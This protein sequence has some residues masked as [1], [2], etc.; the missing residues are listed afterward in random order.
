[1]RL[2]CS[3]A[4]VSERVLT[5]IITVCDEAIDVRGTI[6]AV[7]YLLLQDS[8]T[9]SLAN[10]RYVTLPQLLEHPTVVR[11]LLQIPSTAVCKGGIFEVQMIGVVRHTV[12]GAACIHG[13]D[14]NLRDAACVSHRVANRE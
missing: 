13:C 9:H 8:R 11:L 14:N 12:G 5:F 4:N 6:W 1:M 7:R 2:P 10:I 3:H